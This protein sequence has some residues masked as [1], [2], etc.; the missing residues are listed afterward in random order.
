MGRTDGHGRGEPT[1]ASGENPTAT[2]GEIPL[3]AVRAA[4]V[5][6]STRLDIRETR[7]DVEHDWGT[8]QSWQRIPEGRGSRTRCRFDTAGCWVASRALSCMAS[9]SKS[10]SR[11]RRRRR[12]G[13]R[14]PRP[15]SGA[16]KQAHAR[17]VAAG[18]LQR[19]TREFRSSAGSFACPAGRTANRELSLVRERVAHDPPRDGAGHAQRIEAAA[20]SLPIDH[21]VHRAARPCCRGLRRWCRSGG[22]ERCNDDCDGAGATARHSRQCSGPLSRRQ[23]AVGEL[24]V[25]PQSTSTRYVRAPRLRR[26]ACVRSAAGGL[27]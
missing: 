1:T 26:E 3:A 25:C 15:R 13:A 22:G 2:Y 14:S 20:G 12:S 11:T 18:A 7:R 4:D 5:W 9:S 16:A 10:P 23:G 24:R 8:P 6:S 17:L 19:D 27:T 21:H